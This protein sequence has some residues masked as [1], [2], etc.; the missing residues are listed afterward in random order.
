VLEK[1]QSQGVHIEDENDYIKNTGRILENTDETVE[2]NYPQWRRFRTKPSKVADKGKLKKVGAY[3]YQLLL[4]KDEKTQVVPIRY[5][6]K[7]EAIYTGVFKYIR[8]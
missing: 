1:A 6:S 5:E 3:Q 8:R 4:K 2:V 7:E